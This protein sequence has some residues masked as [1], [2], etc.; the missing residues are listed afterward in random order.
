MPSTASAP[1]TLRAR[2]W[3]SRADGPTSGTARWPPRVARTRRSRNGGRRNGPGLP[4]PAPAPP[5][6]P[7]PGPAPYPGGSGRSIGST[8]GVPVIRRV[9]RPRVRNDHAQRTETT[10]LLAN[11]MR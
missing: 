11:P 1:A 8:S 7:G 10:I 6:Y 4:L 9:L 2:W 3:C 5:P